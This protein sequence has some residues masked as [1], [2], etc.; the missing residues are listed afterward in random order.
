MP[1]VPAVASDLRKAAQ[2]RPHS[3]TLRDFASFR[4]QVYRGTPL[5]WFEGALSRLALFTAV[6][7]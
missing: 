3:R 5:P 4:N 6:T 2:Q 7:T 1:A